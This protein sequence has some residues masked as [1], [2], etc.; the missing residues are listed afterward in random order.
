VV[1]PIAVLHYQPANQLVIAGCLVQKQ[2]I[3][4]TCAFTLDQENL[5]LVTIHLAVLHAI[6]TYIPIDHGG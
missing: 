2:M 1:C 4:K 3:R 6:P 5:G